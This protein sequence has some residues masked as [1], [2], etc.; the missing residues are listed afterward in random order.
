MFDRFSKAYRNPVGAVKEQTEVTFTVKPPR[1]LGVREAFLEIMP[2]GEAPLRL[3]LVWEDTSFG[4][5]CYRASF[6]PQTGLYFYS[7]LLLT[8]KGELR[9][10]EQGRTTALKNASEPFT[11]FQLTAYDALFRTPDFL[12][13]GVIYQIFPDRFCRSELRTPDR[14]R[15]LH[16]NFFEAPDYHND[17]LKIT[18]SDFFGGDLNGITQKLD[19]LSSLGV[20]V[21][22][23]NPIFESY[24]NHRYDTGDYEKIDPLLGTE[25][26][27]RRLFSEAKKRG[28]AVLLDGVFSHTGADSRY[29][30]KFGTYS[31]VGA[32]QSEQSPFSPWYD[33]QHFPDRY[34]CWWGVWSLPCVNETA[35]SFLSF[36][37]GENGIARRYIRLGASGWRLDVADE[38]PD[39]FLDA[40]RT[41]V[42]AENPDAAVLGEVWED[43]SNKIAYGARRRYLLGKQLDSVM[44]YP[45]R[46]AILSFVRDGDA[47]FFADTV[48]SVCEHYPPPVLHG[49]MNMLSTHD[50]PRALTAL[51]GEAANGRD[52]DFQART[53]LSESE[54]PRAYR[55]L[56]LASAV[57]YT[58]PGTPSLYYGDETGLQGYGDPFNRAPFPWGSENETLLAAF[59]FLGELRREISAFAPFTLL[60]VSEHAV[61]YRRGRVTVYANAG[62]TAEKLLGREIPA[63]KCVFTVDGTELTW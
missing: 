30:N 53:R 6:C 34:T 60:A 10:S 15:T 29:F 52:R 44:N 38:L 26:D 56:L 8:G 63:E 61:C 40:F 36:I 19:Y 23:L 50:T 20:T 25:E 58:L 59:R 13:G 27:L 11:P 46:S 31:S 1:S 2:D 41:A 49:L 16:E 24:S 12:K 14:G 55:L 51:A 33:F 21:L 4:T 22:Y 42:K 54:L 7:F 5:D 48:L 32:A 9:L 18:N 45:F 62:K 17:P 43:A 3:P 39:G 47:A 28:I 57:Q 37:T 35:P